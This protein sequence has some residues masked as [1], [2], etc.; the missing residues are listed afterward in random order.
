MHKEFGGEVAGPRAHQE[1]GHRQ[2]GRV[3]QPARRARGPFQSCWG[4]GCIIGMQMQALLWGGASGRWCVA[5]GGL[6]RTSRQT[7]QA[8][9]KGELVAGERMLL[10]SQARGFLPCYACAGRW[11]R[12]G[13]NIETEQYCWPCGPRLLGTVGSQDIGNL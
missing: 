11:L 3:C 1:G 8:S 10:L 6:A 5:R 7:S 2:P 13:L 4:L 9:L 12:S